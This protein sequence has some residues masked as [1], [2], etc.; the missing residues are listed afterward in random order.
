[1]VRCWTC[2][3]GHAPTASLTLNCF[4]DRK[5]YGENIIGIRS[6]LLFSLRFVFETFLSSVYWMAEGC[7]W[8]DSR[9]RNQRL[10]KSRE[11]KI[12]P[13]VPRDSEQKMTALARISSNL[14]GWPTIEFLTSVALEGQN[15]KFIFHG[16]AQSVW[17]RATGRMAKVRF[18]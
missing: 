8:T 5:T 13:W 4:H 12:R 15:V 3:F 16:I 10:P 7:S 9:I 18:Q 11:C 6:A 17:R 1:M 14:P 2:K